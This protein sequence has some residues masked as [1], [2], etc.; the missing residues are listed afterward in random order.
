MSF[1]WQPLDASRKCIKKKFR[2]VANVDLPT[3]DARVAPFDM[4]CPLCVPHVFPIVYKYIP[5]WRHQGYFL[6]NDVALLA[7]T[8]PCLIKYV[9]VPY[10][11]FLF[12]VSVQ[13]RTLVSA[14]VDSSNYGNITF[15]P[16]EVDRGV[17]AL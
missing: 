16:C 12:P 10:L 17:L 3:G 4:H 2:D 15:T 7:C 11:G 9:I 13:E 1:N 6:Y 5:V 14:G 8:P